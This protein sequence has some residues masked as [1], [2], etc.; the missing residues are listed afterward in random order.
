MVTV[1]STAPASTDRDPTDYRRLAI[2]VARWTEAAGCRGLLVYTDNSLLDP[3]AASLLMMSQTRELVPLVAVQPVYMHPFTVA[4][5]VSTLQFLH[6]RTVDLNFVTGG[7]AQHMHALGCAL[8]HDA[9][10]DRLLEYVQAVRDLLTS[11]RPCSYRGEYYQLDRVTLHPRSDRALSPAMF[12]SGSSDASRR[13]QLSLGVPRLAYPRLVGEYSD[14]HESLQ[15]SGIRIGIIARDSA[16]EAWDE[17]HRRFPVDQTGEEL[18]EMAARTVES[19]WHQELSQRALD[20][21]APVG[22]YWLYPFRA[23]KTFCPYLVGD[24]RQVGEFLAAYLRHGVDTIVLD[25]PKAE[26]DLGHS[27]MAL[28]M[29]TRSAHRLVTH[30]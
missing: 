4:R 29:A 5:M 23:Y 10:Y 19:R 27:M 16:A 6:G 28:D 26:D 12:I 21:S 30:A 11:S 20:S 3:W 2:D 14:P 1:Y 15:D 9:R 17:A 13:T 22:P 24:Y 7:F 8:E 18:H 25:V